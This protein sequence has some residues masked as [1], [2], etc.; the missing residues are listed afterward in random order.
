MKTH[1]ITKEPDVEFDLLPIPKRC[2]DCLHRA[3]GSGIGDFCFYSGERR[4]IDVDVNAEKPTWCP[5]A[6]GYN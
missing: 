3:D 6:I 1:K 5:I 4:R 2:V